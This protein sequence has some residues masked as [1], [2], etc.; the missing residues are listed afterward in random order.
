MLGGHS[1]NKAIGMQQCIYMLNLCPLPRPLPPEKACVP[2][3][4][5]LY[6]KFAVRQQHTHAHDAY[7]YVSLCRDEEHEITLQ[8]GG[9]EDQQL[10]S[11][12]SPQNVRATA[13]LEKSMAFNAP[14]KT[15]EPLQRLGSTVRAS[16]RPFEPPG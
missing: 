5:Q 13:A 16:L 11:R 14:A 1:T 3:Q 4:Y 6:P 7:L 2:F 8:P 15:T 10:I 12:S 9:P